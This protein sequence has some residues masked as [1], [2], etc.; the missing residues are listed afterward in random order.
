MSFREGWKAAGRNP[1]V[2]CLLMA[3][4]FIILAAA[5]FV[6]ML[7]GPGGIVLAAAG[8]TLVLR[9]SHWA[10]RRYVHFKRRQPRA[11][12]WCDWGMRRPSAR[13]REALRKSHSGLSE[14]AI[15]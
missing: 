9:N 5:P 14:P 6:G 11:G 8:L 10:K 15:D 3:L 4:G 13:R 1:M 12:S 2:K 7:P